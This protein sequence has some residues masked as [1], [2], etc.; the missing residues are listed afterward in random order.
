LSEEWGG[1]G[2]GFVAAALAIEEVARVDP[3]NAD[4]LS[5]HTALV[6]VPVWRFGNQAQRDR[7]LRDLAGD[8]SL[9]AFCL[10]EEGAGSDVLAVA[11]TARREG[12]DYLLD[13]RKILEERIR[14]CEQR[15]IPAPPSSLGAD[16]G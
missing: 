13:G 5:A 9:G 14:R 11:T 8:R 10:T 3:S 16:W 4:T 15:L 1:G 6:T 12:D 2:A 7:W